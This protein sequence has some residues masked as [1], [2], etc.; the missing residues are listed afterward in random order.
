L[1]NVREVPEKKKEYSDLDFLLDACEQNTS[2]F[3]KEGGLTPEMVGRYVIAA[4][5]K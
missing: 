2:D 4:L 3:L 5:M 1:V